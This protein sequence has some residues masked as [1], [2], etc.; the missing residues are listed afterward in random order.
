MLQLEDT[1]RSFSRSNRVLVPMARP[2]YACVATS[3]PFAIRLQVCTVLAHGNRAGIADGRK[4][5][6]RLVHRRIPQAHDKSAC[7]PA[8]S[9]RLTSTIDQTRSAV[10]HV[11]VSLEFY[12]GYRPDSSAV[13]LS[14]S[15]CL[16]PHRGRPSSDQRCCSCRCPSC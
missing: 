12:S 2:C 7:T 3:L 9:T 16:Q 15:Q 5:T 6:D 10:M 4:C 14:A 8:S 13:Q 1:L 11:Q